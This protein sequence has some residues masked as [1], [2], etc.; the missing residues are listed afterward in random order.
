[1][2]DYEVHCTPVL[3]MC[4]STAGAQSRVNLED[5]KIDGELQKEGLSLT[6]RQHFSI[7]SEIE[8]RDSFRDLVLEYLPVGYHRLDETPKADAE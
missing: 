5:V 2:L 3:F 1:M 4:L 7:E 8:V 6:S